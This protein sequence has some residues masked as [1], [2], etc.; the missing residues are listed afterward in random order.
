[1]E[2]RGLYIFQGQLQKDKKRLLVL[3]PSSSG[4]QWETL[5]KYPLASDPTQ[6]KKSIKLLPNKIRI[7]EKYSPKQQ[8]IPTP[9]TP[10]LKKK[11]KNKGKTDLGRKKIEKTLDKGP[12]K[13]ALFL[14]KFTLIC[15]RKHLYLLFFTP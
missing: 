4:V 13:V 7:L 5:S 2:T 6:K 14:R 3:A 15:S 12:K 1:M 9:T 8:N 10:H 11:K